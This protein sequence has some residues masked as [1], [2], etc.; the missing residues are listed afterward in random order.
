MHDASLLYQIQKGQPREHQHGHLHRHPVEMSGLV[1][2]R[3]RLHHPQIQMIREH[4]DHQR[5]FLK[6]LLFHRHQYL[7]ESQADHVAR[8]QDRYVDMP[9]T[10]TPKA[11]LVYPSEPEL[12]W[13]FQE[14][15][16]PLQ[17]D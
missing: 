6:C 14:I 7:P 4:E 13:R 3:H 16:L 15:L 1:V 5:K 17:T 8:I 9:V 2:P 12:D 10:Y 11:D